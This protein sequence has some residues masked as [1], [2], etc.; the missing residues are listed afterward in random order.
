MRML[1]SNRNTPSA[2]SALQV[3][4]TL[5]LV[6][7]ALRRNVSKAPKPYVRL[8]RH[9]KASATGDDHSSRRPSDED[10]VMNASEQQDNPVFRGP[11]EV[12]DG[13]STTPNADYECVTPKKART[14]NQEDYSDPTI[15]DSAEMNCDVEAEDRPFTT[16]TYK[17]RFGTSGRDRMGD[18]ASPPPGAAVL[19]SV[20]GSLAHP[21]GTKG[22]ASRRT[23]RNSVDYAAS[24]R[25]SC[26]VLAPP[27][28]SQSEASSRADRH[29]LRH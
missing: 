19:S 22:P 3:L 17:A 12:C 1:L 21:P 24:R 14:D 13:P 10:E 6:L 15:V 16:V 20:D 26:G 5:S 11:E 18:A 8:P 28:D 25:A 9:P 23:S 4:D 29:R 2:Q 7:A 27:A